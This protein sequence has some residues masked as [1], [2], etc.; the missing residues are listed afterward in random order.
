MLANV[1][2]LKFIHIAVRKSERQRQEAQALVK[3]AYIHNISRHNTIAR[4][5][6]ATLYNVR[7]PRVWH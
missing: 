6:R 7:S 3:P 1:I 5:E 2:Y 4:Y